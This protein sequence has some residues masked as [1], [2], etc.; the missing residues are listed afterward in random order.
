MTAGEQCAGHYSGKLA[1][2]ACWHTS[3]SKPNNVW[4]D[5]IHRLVAVAFVLHAVVCG[6]GYTTIEPVNDEW[7]ADGDV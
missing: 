1:R 4:F 6:T 7:I 2:P 5:D 3:Y